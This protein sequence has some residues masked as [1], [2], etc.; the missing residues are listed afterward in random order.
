MVEAI[1]H[2]L[3]ESPITVYNFEVEDFHTYHVGSASVLV[4]NSCNH[5]SIW[6][7]ERRNYWKMRSK[8]DMPGQNY[9]TYMATKGNID[10]MSKGCAPIGWDGYRVHLHHWKGILNDFY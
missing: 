4:H 10:L 9:G 7:R 3:L 6:A 1:E 5:N 2:E 8:L